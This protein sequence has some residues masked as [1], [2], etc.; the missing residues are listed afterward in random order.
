MIVSGRVLKDWKRAG[1]GVFPHEKVEIVE[2]LPKRLEK[3]PPPDYYWL[4]GKRMF[5][6]KM[7]FEA[8]GFCGMHFCPSCGRQDHDVDA[9]YDRQNDGR[10]W[11][12]A[13]VGSSWNGSH[14]FTVDLSSAT[15]FCTEAVVECA[16]RNK[17]TNFCFVPAERAA[18]STEGIKYLR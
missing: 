5:G 3:V 15:F 8:S 16:R 4:D 10:T 1:I 2:P 7:D 14:V 18:S 17:H 13:I 12:M 11:P 9:T 6:A